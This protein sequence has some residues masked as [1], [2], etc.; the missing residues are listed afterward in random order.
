MADWHHGCG[1]ERGRAGSQPKR[2]ALCMASIHCV[3]CGS[4]WDAADAGRPA[5]VSAV[6]GSAW[7]LMLMSMFNATPHAAGRQCDLVEI[8]IWLRYYFSEFSCRPRAI[9]QLR[10]SANKSPVSFNLERSKLP[11][12]QAVAR[13]QRQLEHLQTAP[14]GNL[15]HNMHPIQKALRT[16]ICSAQCSKHLA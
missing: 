10:D 7:M 8:V 15:R 14:L 13:Q 12:A 6:W 5:A 3:C 1:L 16:H 2:F 11:V 9:S 4:S